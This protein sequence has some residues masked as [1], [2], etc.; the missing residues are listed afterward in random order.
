MAHRF[1]SY[2]E[3]MKDSILLLIGRVGVSYRTAEERNEGGER[4]ALLWWSVSWLQVS[5]PVSVGALVAPA[6][7]VL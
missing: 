4:D 5:F 1:D 2:L 3:R 7:D 6:L